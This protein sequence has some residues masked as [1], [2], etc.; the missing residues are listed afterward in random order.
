MPT[1]TRP[2]DPGVRDPF[3]LV[4]VAS[5][6]ADR[7]SVSDMVRFALAVTTSTSG[8]SCEHGH[9]ELFS[10]TVREWCA[11]AQG[12][13]ERHGRWLHLRRRTGSAAATFPLRRHT[14][15][16]HVLLHNF[17]YVSVGWLWIS[18]VLQDRGASGLSGH[19][20]AHAVAIWGLPGRAITLYVLFSATGRGRRL[21][22]EMSPRPWSAVADWCP[23]RTSPTTQSTAAGRIG[24]RSI[25]N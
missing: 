8:P 15:V 25:V 11:D 3:A 4:G 20:L 9:P 21:D 24:H 7:A 13:G 22:I 23:S 14:N 16:W 17:S 2:F 12:A 10:S 6:R 19:M 1:V 5:T 18:Q